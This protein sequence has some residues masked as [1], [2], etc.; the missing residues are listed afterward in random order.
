MIQKLLGLAHAITLAYPQCKQ[1]S[2]TVIYMDFFL[3]TF[4]I[5]SLHKIVYGFGTFTI[6]LQEH[7]ID[8]SGYNCIFYLCILKC[9]ATI[10]DKC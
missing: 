5:N 8:I 3:S 10:A 9:A 6:L 2:S 4:N 1:C 7:F